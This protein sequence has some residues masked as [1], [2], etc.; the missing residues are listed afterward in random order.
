MSH[1]QA[2][3][4]D[5]SN[6]HVNRKE[7]WVIFLMLFALTVL[8]VGVVFIPGIAK[9]HLI[10][11]LVIMALVKAALVSLFFMH[12]NHETKIVRWG[13][14]GPLMIPFLY[15]AALVADAMVRLL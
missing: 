13:V 12:L 1:D 3:I 5:T 11:V 10:A 6:V 14:I 7:Y 15:A 9:A 4:T 2:H 8:E